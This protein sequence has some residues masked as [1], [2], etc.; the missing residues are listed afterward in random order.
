MTKIIF[1]CTV[2]ILL[3][4]S[5][6][7]SQTITA[8]VD[9]SQQPF[10]KKVKLI[11]TQIEKITKEEKA[12]LKL[13]VE[14]VTVKLENKEIT[15]EEA[16]REKQILAETRA[17]NIEAKVA[18][19]QEKLNALVQQKV[20][21]R[22]QTSDSIYDSYTFSIPSMK[23]KKNK[24][25]KEK[26]T[27][28]QFVLAFGQNNVITDQNLDNSDFSFWQSR[29]LEWGFTENTGLFKN[30]NLLHL[31]YGFSVMYNNL[32]PTDNRYFVTAPSDQTN[33]Q[34]FSNELTESRLKN[35]YL[36]A[37]LHLE[38]DFSKNK[39]KNDSNHFKTH[40]GLR[41]GI[42]GYGGL[43]IKTKQKL[44]YDQGNDTE[45]SKTK[46][47]FNSSNFIYGLNT[48]LGYKET[49]LYLK[50]D[51]NPLFKNNLVDQNNVSLGVRFDF[52]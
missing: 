38:F 6:I 39:S 8:K 34:V 42:G 37:P 21:G 32:S 24:D 48:Y 47:D 31:K 28:S 50:Y 33:L 3:F 13:E 20:D 2:C 5:T 40:K 9:L 18:V 7:Q 16:I 14:A 44:V 27:T 45:Q 52:N 25:T 49:S 41:L 15:P 35:V 4:S 43:R 23:I 12:A 11:A 10:E 29:F 51:L 17:K 1:Y 26:R 36:V 30:D 46:G 19:E 22:L